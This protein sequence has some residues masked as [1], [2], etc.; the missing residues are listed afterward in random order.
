MINYMHYYNIILLINGRTA[1]GITMSIYAIT[2][3]G[4]L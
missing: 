3:S 4:S 2:Q 1:S